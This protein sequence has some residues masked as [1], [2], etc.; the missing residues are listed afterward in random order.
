MSVISHDTNCAACGGN[1]L[2]E[3]EINL[4]RISTWLH[5]LALCQPDCRMIS[6]KTPG[7]E[8]SRSSPLGHS[9]KLFS[10][11][12]SLKPS[13]SYLISHDGGGGQRSEIVFTKNE[14]N[15]LEMCWS[16]N[17]QLARNHKFNILRCCSCRRACSVQQKQPTSKSIP[18]QFRPKSR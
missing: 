2:L 16:V 3:P 13:L 10:T 11:L 14:P 17:I 4:R 18:C 6:F 12:S 5:I 8:R 1:K 15:C 9:S 7:L